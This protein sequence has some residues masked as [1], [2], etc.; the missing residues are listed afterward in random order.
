MMRLLEKLPNVGI[1]MA[2]SWPFYGPI[3][4]KLPHDVLILVHENNYSVS[5]R[6]MKEIEETGY[7]SIF[8]M[9]HQLQK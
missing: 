9:M 2:K 6:N 4:S 8:A 1:K 5:E 3:F 7:K